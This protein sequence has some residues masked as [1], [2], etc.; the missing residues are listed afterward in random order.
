MLGFEAIQAPDV[1]RLVNVKIHIFFDFVI[2]T[3]DFS[4]NSKNFQN[5]LRYGALL[6]KQGGF[7]YKWLELQL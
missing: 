2:F 3:H 7:L 4:T 6:K 1:C 5:S